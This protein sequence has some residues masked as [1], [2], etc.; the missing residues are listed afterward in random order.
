MADQDG[1]PRTL[2]LP[3][4]FAVALKQVIGGG[5]IVLTATAIDLTGA[6]AII[7][8]ALA[9]AV[10]LLVSLPYAVLGAAM[11]VSGGLY[12]WPARLIGPRA[13]F[14]GF[15][16]VLGTHV[17]LAAY[18]A[19]FGAMLHALLPWVPVRLG[20]PGAL[21]AILVLNLLGARMSA[22]AGVALTLVVA[23]SLI[24]LA[25]MGL[26]EIDPRR[27]ED[28][29]PHGWHGLLAVAALLTY[30]VSGATL[31]AELAGEMRRPGRD[32]PIA[33]LG[34][35]ACAALLYIAVTV[36]AVGL[37]AAPAGPRTLDVVARAVMGRYGFVLFSL[38]AGLVSMAGIMNTHLLWGSRSVLLGCRDG[39]L[40]TRFGRPNRRG[41]PAA[42]LLL[43]ALIGGA[44]VLMGLDVADIIRMS[45][46]GAAGSAMLSIACAP[47][48]A[49]ADPAGYAASAL[50]IPP[51]A[52]LAA[53]AVAIASE[54][55]TLVLV[56]RD[57][58][59]RL[60]LL[61][62]GWVAIGLVIAMA[63]S[64]GVGRRFAGPPGA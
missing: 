44:P 12:R 23:L 33:I 41:A 14:V 9:C 51:A 13:G 54:I 45:A 19:T 46:L 17:G 39:W 40:P 47:L 34:A 28:M 2:D 35:T 27:L 56:L 31:V 48:Y 43:L 58:S 64:P 15:W 37:P 52:L 8:Y 59:M 60:T 24:G 36:V 3:R 11:P 63:R 25:A 29:L 42:P 62:L 18:A 10:V 57:L 5:V 55:A 22:G 21:A 7:A 38:G 6:G 26:P 49:R 30:P 53:V 32:V 16:M 50:A 1:L 61:W 20:G 4:V